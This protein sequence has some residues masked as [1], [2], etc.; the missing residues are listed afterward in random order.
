MLLPEGT[1][2]C[3]S[4][5]CWRLSACFRSSAPAREVGARPALATVDLRISRISLQVVC[6]S[7]DIAVISGALPADLQHRG[8][9]VW[10]SQGGGGT[11]L[12]SVERP[13]GGGGDGPRQPWCKSSPQ[14]LRCK[15]C[16]GPWDEPT[17][18]L[19]PM[20]VPGHRQRLRSMSSSECSDVR[21]CQ[22]A[23]QQNLA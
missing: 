12:R 8:P 20:P 19:T 22:T 16:A 18:S 6:C 21:P 13:R 15:I 23:C 3:S 9:G 4:T 7:R 1:L 10:P 2:P 17:R 5:A 11:G 14:D